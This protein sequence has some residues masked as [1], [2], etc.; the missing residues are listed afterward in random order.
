MVNPQHYPIQTFESKVPF[1][2]AT[3]PSSA[4]ARWANFQVYGETGFN[5]TGTEPVFREWT[6]TED[7]PT[8]AEASVVQRD[9]RSDYSVH[10]DCSPL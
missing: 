6:L 3:P 8:A 7:R 5:K 4:A 1:K 10:G 2:I 9:F